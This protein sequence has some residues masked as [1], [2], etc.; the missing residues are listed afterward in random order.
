[1]M[2]TTPTFNVFI[3]FHLVSPAPEVKKPDAFCMDVRG[4][5]F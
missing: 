4:V 5:I 1:V 3:N 2:R